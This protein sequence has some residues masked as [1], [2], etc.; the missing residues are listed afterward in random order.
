M[1][2]Q[3][4]FSGAGR[5]INAAGRTIRYESGTAAAGDESIRV[6]ADGQ[7]L[8][9]ML[10]GD[11][12]R[13]PRQAQLWEVVPVDANCNG[14][15]RVGPAEFESSRSVG[16]LTIGETKYPRTLKHR[17][18]VMSQSAD[19]DVGDVTPRFQL[20]NPA[21]SGRALI[22]QAVRSSHDLTGYAAQLWI[23]TT[24]LAMTSN[25]GSSLIQE[26]G[27]AVSKLT[28]LL[29]THGS[30]LG[31]GVIKSTTTSTKIP[32]FSM[33]PLLTHAFDGEPNALSSPIIVMPGYGLHMM[34]YA[35]G[36]TG[37]TRKWSRRIEWDE[38]PVS[39]L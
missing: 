9:L 36:G 8:G 29:S 22:V 3:Y 33:N 27:A 2:Q 12:A 19:A 14:V 28:G 32:P 10:P 16:T 35:L 20:W 11:S 6:R 38:I 5:I 37:A 1:I 31:A 26:K 15:V 39:E 30:V 7:D 24:E 23:D 21:A 13:L 18:F 25:Q 34:S 4:G 17:S